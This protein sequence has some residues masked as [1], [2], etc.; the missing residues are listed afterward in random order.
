[1]DEGLYFLVEGARMGQGMTNDEKS[2][3]DEVQKSNNISP[4]RVFRHLSFGFLSSFGIRHSSFISAFHFR[5]HFVIASPR[6]SPYQL[7][8]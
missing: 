1:V 7:G 8:A 4:N 2:P 3:N 6:V 5:L